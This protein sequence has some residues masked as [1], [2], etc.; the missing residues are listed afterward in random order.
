M[1]N[2]LSAAM[3]LRSLMTRLSFASSSLKLNGFCIKS[4][5]PALITSV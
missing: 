3:R 5:A 1:D 2:L 4:L